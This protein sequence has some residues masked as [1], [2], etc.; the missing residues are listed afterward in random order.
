M[1]KNPIWLAF[2]ALNFAVFLWFFSVASYRTYDYYTLSKETKPLNL[3]WFVEE[4][5]SDDFRVG[6]TYSY[7]DNQSG[8]TIFSDR[9]FRNPLSAD[10]ELKVKESKKFIVYYNPQNINHSSLQKT[11][12]TKECVSAGVLLLLSLYFVGLGMYAQNKKS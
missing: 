11:F 6:A 10:D 5:S 7:L 2:L 3:K 12:P 1:N 9:K 4:I 8:E